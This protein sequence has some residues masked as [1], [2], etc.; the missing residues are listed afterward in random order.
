MPAY[1]DL[2]TIICAASGPSL[3]AQDCERVSALGLPVIAVNNT[4]QRFPELLALYAGDLAW[5][6]IN[7]Q[8]V[9][10]GRFR[11]VT[12]SLSAHR[13]YPFLEYRRYCADKETYNSGA[14]AIEYAA[15]LGAKRILLIG[16]DCSIRHGL[17]WHGDH[18][19]GLTNPS[20]AAPDIWQNQFLRAKQRLSG[21][22]IINCSRRTELKCFPLKNL[23]LALAPLS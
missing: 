16:Y 14:M 18:Q 21:V 5:W 1:S 15:E 2:S 23:E 11:C 19:P 12:A 7:H 22:E 20:E 6:N 9:P 10:Q 13:K 17:H 8:L 4:W 3:T